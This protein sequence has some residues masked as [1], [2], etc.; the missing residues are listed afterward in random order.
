MSNLKY[1]TNEN[2]LVVAIGEEGGIRKDWEFG[3]CRGK[4]LYIKWTNNKV[5]LYSTRN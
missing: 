2:T 4:L 3:I 5:L 1:D